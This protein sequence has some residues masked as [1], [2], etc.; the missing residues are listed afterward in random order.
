MN[1]KSLEYKVELMP[2]RVSGIVVEGHKRG[3]LLGF[4]TANVAPTSPLH[5][6]RGVYAVEVRLNGQ[7]FKGMGNYGFKPTFGFE[8]DVLEVHIFD[9]DDNIYGKEISV[10]FIKYLRPEV[11]FSS[12]AAL[13]K[14]L[15]KDK[16]LCRQVLD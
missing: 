12:P 1:S 10:I 7:L 2:D 15:I 9:F 11:K 4:P 16:I 6:A 3:R 5:I 8:E 14:Q 13:R